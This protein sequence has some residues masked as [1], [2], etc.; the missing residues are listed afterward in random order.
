MQILVQLFDPIFL[1]AATYLILL[2]IV[3]SFL[4]LV[5]GFRGNQQNC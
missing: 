1:N 3:H 4:F 5:R 2:P